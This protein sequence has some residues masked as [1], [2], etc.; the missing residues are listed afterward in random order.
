MTASAE[1]AD[2]KRP[3]RRRV[4]RPA[5]AAG[6]SAWRTRAPPRW[7]S[8]RP[9]D[10]AGDLE[11]ARR[12]EIDVRR[13]GWPAL[14]VTGVFAYAACPRAP[15]TT[16][17]LSPASRPGT[18]QTPASSETAVPSTHGSVFASAST[19]PKSFFTCHVTATRTPG[20]GFPS[21]P[22]TCPPSPPA[23]P[24]RDRRHRTSHAPSTEVDI[25]VTPRPCRGGRAAHTPSRAARCGT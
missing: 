10:G 16:T 8:R 4:H 20:N 3:V 21:G 5:A 14:T 6:G 12:S 11:R 24:V 1:P 17:V 18:A 15:R 13:A 9:H 22:V 2:A 7:A 19:T 23:V 25:R